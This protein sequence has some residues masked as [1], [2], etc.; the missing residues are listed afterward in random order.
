MKDQSHAQADA[1]GAQHAYE[2]PLIN[3]NLSA[4]FIY[5]FYL[6]WK[7]LEDEIQAR[8]DSKKAM[9][10]N[11]RRDS[12]LQAGALKIAMRRALMKPNKKH[13]DVLFSTAALHYSDLLDAEIEAREMKDGDVN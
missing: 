13:E 6:A 9:M 3:D 5:N 8:Q 12:P 7:E 4:E 10:A 1:H 2:N 11:V